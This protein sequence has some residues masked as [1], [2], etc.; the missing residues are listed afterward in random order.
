MQIAVIGAGNMGCLYGSNFARVGEQV[1]M[2]DVWKEHVDQMQAEGL[3]MD[4][5]HGNFVVSVRATTD[6]TS[7]PK[8]DIAVI[9]VNGYSTR[10]AANAARI[11]LKDSGYALTLQNGLGNVEI[12]TEVL[13]KERVLA[14]L[15]FHSAELIKPGKVM[16]TNHGPTYIG[17]LDQSQSSRLAALNDLMTRACL[18]PVWVEDI[19]ATMWAK[20]VHNCGINALCAITGLRP[21][22]LQEVPEVDKF[23]THIIHEALALVKA[24]SIKLPEEN[25]LE[26]IKAYCAKKFHKVSMVQHLERGRLTEIDSLNGYIVRESKKLGLPCPYNE[27]LTS[28][29]KGL[30]HLPADGSKTR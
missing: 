10:D 8:V 17:E 9:C 16:H 30:Q 25:P 19:V 5:L 11:V 26:T 1:T 21:G 23:Q 22:H 28:L 20:F 7:A 18:E 24:N 13:G 15:S 4:G 27:S 3:E 14:G 6:P 29:I 2:I 12:L